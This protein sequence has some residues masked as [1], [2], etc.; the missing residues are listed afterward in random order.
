M[1]CCTASTSEGTSSTDTV[2]SLDLCQPMRSRL[3]GQDGW[4][5][6]LFAVAVVSWPT[7]VS[8]MNDLDMAR[9]FVPDIVEVHANG[10]NAFSDYTRAAGDF[11]S[12][13]T[14]LRGSSDELIT[15]I[16]SRHSAYGYDQRLEA[17]GSDGMLQVDNTRPTTVRASPRQPPRRRTR[18]PP[19]SWIATTTP[20][21][22]NWTP[23]SP[24][25]NP[26]PPAAP[27]TS[28]A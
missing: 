18:T 24:R 10:A 19:G 25:S 9:F 3:V 5:A 6:F 15:I 17:F 4:S 26:E 11:H 12:A 14:T 23:S 21:D 27:T 13:V 16:N 7:V 20:T 22:G 2:T 1:A 8:E 28:T